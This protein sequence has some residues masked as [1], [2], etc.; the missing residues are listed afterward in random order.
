V[1]LAKDGDCK[2]AQASLAE[3]RA[4]AKDSSTLAAA[5]QSVDGTCH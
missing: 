4:K 3:A 1:A 2:G 5:E